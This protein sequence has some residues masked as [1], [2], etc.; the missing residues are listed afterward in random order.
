MADPSPELLRF[1]F[2]LIR[3]Y[4]RIFDYLLSG[5]GIGFRTDFPLLME[6]PVSRSRDDRIAKIDDAKSNLQDALSALSEL[7]SEAETNKAELEEALRR[8]AEARAGH[9]AE[10]EQLEQIR[11]IAEADITAFR[12]MAGINPARERLI[13]FLGGVAASLIA[14]GLWK[15]GELLLS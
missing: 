10:A 11:A 5:V 15:V 8:L 12:R 9:A 6:V 14:A 1:L 13:G 2:R 3:F 4:F 7:K